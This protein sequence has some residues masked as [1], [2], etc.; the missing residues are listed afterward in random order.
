[1]PPVADRVLRPARKRLGDP[2]PATAVLCDGANDLQILLGGPRLTK[3]K[4]K[5]VTYNADD[6]THP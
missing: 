5:Q 4:K 2:I 3:K 6:Y 1:M